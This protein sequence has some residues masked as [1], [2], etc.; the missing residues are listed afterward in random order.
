MKAEIVPNQ[1]IQNVEKSKK[2]KFLNR[3]IFLGGTITLIIGMIGIVL[4][5]LP[6]T[7]FLLISAAAYAKSSKRFYK[8]LIN[9]K[10]LG[11]YIRNYKEGK[12]MPIKLKIITL[13]ILWITIIISL[14]F[15]NNLIWIQIILL[16]VACI[17]SIHIISIKPK[18]D[19]TS[20]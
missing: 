10:F 7:P 5:I 19:K 9:S 12:G 20:I 11:T 6:T 1:D 3:I 17:V 14:F 8:W 18:R 15:M 16:I 4:P 2:K 13:I